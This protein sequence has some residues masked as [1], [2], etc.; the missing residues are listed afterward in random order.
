MMFDVDGVA[1][2]SANFNLSLVER[3]RLQQPPL[4]DLH[5]FIQDITT[6]EATAGMARPMTFHGTP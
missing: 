4:K 3:S 5:V 2:T 6:V 1:L